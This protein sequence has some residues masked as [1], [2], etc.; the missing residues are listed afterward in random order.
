M[1]SGDQRHGTMP[2]QM[3]VKELIPRS[4][5]AVTTG[6]L[7]IITRMRH[8]KEEVKEEVMNEVFNA[9]ELMTRQDQLDG[10]VN[11]S[12]PGLQLWTTLPLAQNIQILLVITLKVVLLG[13]KK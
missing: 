12:A 2:E 1:P 5:C 11:V 6:M 3:I 9:L 10:A 4:S 8:V 7:G 13:G